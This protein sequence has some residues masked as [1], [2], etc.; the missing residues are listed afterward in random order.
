MIQ[1][2]SDVLPLYTDFNSPMQNQ[3]YQLQLFQK[4]VHLCFFD[5]WHFGLIL[6]FLGIK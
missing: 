2:R 1:F 3:S 4:G 5:D 6:Q